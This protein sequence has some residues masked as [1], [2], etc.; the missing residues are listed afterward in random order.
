VS[1][2]SSAVAGVP[3]EDA[4]VASALL[5]ASQQLGGSLG[6]AVLSA[7]ASARFDA[8][9]PRH[10]TPATLAAAETSSWAYAFVAGAGL[11]IGAAIVGGLLIR[12][13]TAEPHP[14]GLTAADEAIDHP[15]DGAALLL[16]TAAV[17]PA[18]ATPSPGAVVRDMARCVCHG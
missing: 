5:N 8:V 7:V 10:P 3:Q 15:A 1:V 6:L 2:T 12:A 9:R 4:G 16:S 14:G 13:T 11:L 17:Q 18:G